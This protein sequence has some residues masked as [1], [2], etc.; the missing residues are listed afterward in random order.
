MTT[1][2]GEGPVAPGSFD[3]PRD[4]PSGPIRTVEDAL[5]VLESHGLKHRSKDKKKDK[6]HKHKKEKKSKHKK[7][8]RRSHDKGNRRHRSDSDSDSSQSR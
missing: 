8:K 3:K 5:A 1:G 6:K 4:V 2:P 7:E